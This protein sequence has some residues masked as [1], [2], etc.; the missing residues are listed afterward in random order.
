MSL[1]RCVFLRA[2][3]L[4]DPQTHTGKFVHSATVNSDVRVGSFGVL[5][6]LCLTHGITPDACVFFDQTGFKIDGDLALHEPNTVT[7]PQMGGTG[8]QTSD[9]AYVKLLRLHSRSQAKLAV[10]KQVSAVT[11]QVISAHGSQWFYHESARWKRIS[12]PNLVPVLVPVFQEASGVFPQGRVNLTVITPWI[13]NGNITEY[14]RKHQG[15]NR[16][17]LV[18]ESAFRA[19]GGDMP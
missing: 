1:I 6:G 10:I 16:L 7:N 11:S 4:P 3:P 17:E 9:A 2:S 18:G 12:H 13:P 8:G 19:T 15:A 5:S 14:L